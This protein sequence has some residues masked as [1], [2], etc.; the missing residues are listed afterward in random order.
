[1]FCLFFLQM[2]AKLYNTSCS[3][4]RYSISFFFRCFFSSYHFSLALMTL[5]KDKLM[6]TNL[7]NYKCF[8]LRHTIITYNYKWCRLLLFLILTAPSKK[9]IFV[10]VKTS[11]GLFLWHYLL[12]AVPPFS[13]DRDWANVYFLFCLY[14]HT[15]RSFNLH[16]HT[17]NL[18]QQPLISIN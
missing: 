15:K 4:R 8:C 16:R 5:W 11:Q 14:L 12:A 3:K 7:Q 13:T 17:K 1:M 10:K 6:Q 18:W 2:K 9:L